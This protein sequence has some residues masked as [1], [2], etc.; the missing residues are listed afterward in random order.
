MINKK[1]FLI[2]LGVFLLLGFST[3]K[4]TSLPADSPVVQ[5][6]KII[7][8][9]SYRVSDNQSEWEKAKVGIAI[10]DG[11]KVR[12]GSSSLAL[13][14]FIDGSGLL[15]VRE[16]SILNIYG[17]S[18]NRKMNKNT[19]IDRGMVG[20]EV[21]KQAEDEEFKFTTPTVVASIRGTE[22]FIEHNDVDTTSTIFLNTG[23]A[24]FQ[25][26]TGAEGTLSSGNTLTV[27]KDGTFSL[28]NSTDEDSTKFKSSKVTTTKQIIIKTKDGE[29]RIEY[30]QDK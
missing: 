8:D 25:T 28:K 21:N 22:G 2:V 5:V 15:R 9:V 12:T 7:K 4:K 30:L 3:E 11:G 13:I 27:K 20:F 16:N 18:E 23:S 10:G 19:F 14:Q 24:T 17:K 1:N 6:K 26:L 29:I